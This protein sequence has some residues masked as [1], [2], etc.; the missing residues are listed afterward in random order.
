MS[1]VSLYSFTTSNGATQPVFNA[2]GGCE[3]P[4]NKSKTRNAKHSTLKSESYTG[5]APPEIAAM[6][7]VDLQ[8]SFFFL[9]SF[10]PRVG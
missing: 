5:P 2:C 1:E 10:E 9:M 3:I 7:T 6:L 8:P 4:N